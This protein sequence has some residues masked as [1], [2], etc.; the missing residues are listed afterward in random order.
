VIHRVVHTQV[1][2]GGLRLLQMPDVV[3]RPTWIN[4][5]VV[6]GRVVA[7]RSG[8]RQMD[9]KHQQI[10]QRYARVTAFLR[11]RLYMTENGLLKTFLRACSRL[12]LLSGCWCIE[13]CSTPLVELS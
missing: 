6:L 2:E 1:D 9:L 5:Q 3:V 8:N 11:Y 13:R 12:A 7:I 4:E 10:A